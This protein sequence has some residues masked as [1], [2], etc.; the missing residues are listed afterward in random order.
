MPVVIIIEAKNENLKGGWDQCTAAMLAAQLSNQQK[1]NEIKKI[2][3]AVRTGDICK[4][5]K[6]VENEIFIDLNNY[7]TKE[8]DKILGILSESVHGDIPGLSS[9]N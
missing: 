4:F 9:T 2:D 6:L 1:G 8:I 3:G 7:Y 5:L